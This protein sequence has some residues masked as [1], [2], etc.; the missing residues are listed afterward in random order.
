MKKEKKQ[1][2]ENILVRW[3]KLC[4]PSKGAWIGQILSFTV[5][6][7]FL[8]LIN[9]FAARTIDCMYN[10]DWNGAFLNLFIEVATI[11][12]RNLAIHVEYRFYGRQHVVIRTNI[13][14]KIYNKILSAERK[15][16]NQI[17]KEKIINI[18]TNNMA[19]AAEFP[20]A[21]ASF[22]ASSIQVVLTLVLVFTSNVLAG[23]IVTALGVF[24]FFIYYTCNKKLG[25]LLL[26]RNEYKDEMYKSFTKVID[27]KDV[28]TELKGR[29]KYE[30]EVI[31]NVQKFAKSYA[32]Y[33]NTYSVKNNLFYAFWNVVVYIITAI[34]L[35][36][37]SKGTLEIAIYLIIVPY[38]KTCTEKL[39]NLFD[40]TS[41]LEN[42]R[43]DVD[44]VNIILGLNDKQLIKYG[45][46]NTETSGYN[47]GL[48]DV[49]YKAED[50]D[51]GLNN[52]DI[53]FKKGCINLIK[54]EKRSGK[55]S[56]FN[57]LRRYAKPDNGKVLLD[58]L[59][60]YYYNEKTFKNHIDYC[61]S[62]PVFINGTIKENLMLKEKKFKRI[63]EICAQIGVDKYIEKLPH[64]Y[65]T[66]IAEIKSS[67][68]LF[69]LG[70][71]RAVLSDSNILMIYELP[72]DGTKVLRNTVIK[73]LTKHYADKTVILFS[74]SNEYDD[75]AE[76]TYEVSNGRVKQA[77]VKKVS[78]ENKKAE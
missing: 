38:L 28:I 76:M 62:H 16:I 71:A 17:S 78:A 68:L 70:L 48:I 24:N 29:K 25:K 10:G 54:G 47:L 19:N 40:K 63:K 41:A 9:I 43:V 33:Y 35:F 27:G 50:D 32:K 60:L 5:Y 67:T 49:S 31:G 7:V 66:E 51:A 12:I 11:V 4:Q 44:R 73:F 42:M 3:Y 46:F 59:D 37:V 18:T 45:K 56:I 69:L 8:T 2:K 57:L 61:A 53:S 74:H 20:D 64:K 52:V 21:V 14:K 36:Y 15:G 77:K 22:F 75:I 23:L 55:R 30:K 1:K 26:Q 58:N 13:A 6:T 65:K 39:T 72:N 34:L